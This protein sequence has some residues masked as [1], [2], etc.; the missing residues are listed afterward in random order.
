M[1]MVKTIEEV[2]LEDYKRGATKE[3]GLDYRIV[4][5]IKGNNFVK[6]ITVEELSEKINRIAN[7]KEAM[8]IM[9]VL[10]LVKTPSV[11]YEEGNFEAY[12]ET[13]EIEAR[14][15]E[16]FKLISHA[17]D[18]GNLEFNALEIHSV[19]WD[20][21]NGYFLIRF[22]ENHMEIMISYLDYSF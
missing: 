17:D 13:R 11:I 19:E 12:I 9:E 8:V 14:I 2:V 10:G 16:T 15:E 4:G 3:S 22:I 7:S 1:E 21:W 6:Q 5:K 18:V 20:R